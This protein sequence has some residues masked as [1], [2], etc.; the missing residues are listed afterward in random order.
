VFKQ[1]AAIIKPE[2]YVDRF[3]DDPE[4]ILLDKDG[5]PWVVN[6]ECDNY[7]HLPKQYYPNLIPGKTEDWLRVYLRSEYGR[8]LSGTPVYE[9]TFVPDFHVSANPLLAIKSP[10]YPIIIGVDFGRTPAAVFKQRDP[11]GRVL[12]LGEVTSENMGI[13]TFIRTKLNPYIANNFQGHTF[14]CAP[15]PAGF[16]K[17]QIGEISPVDVLKRAGFKVSKPQS[18]DPERRIMAVERLLTANVGGKPTVQINPSCANLVKGFK[19]GYRY[20]LNKAGIQDNKPFKNEYSHVHDACQYGCMIIEGNL[21]LGAYPG[22]T[23]RRDIKRVDY[24][25]A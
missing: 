14:V 3:N 18:N 5:E 15:D 1:P 16:A 21:L 24:D 22:Q 10:G 9:K 17:Q 12:T 6:P 11:R 19:F 7:D 4:D 25:F 8:S 2:V 23:A 20:A 13:E